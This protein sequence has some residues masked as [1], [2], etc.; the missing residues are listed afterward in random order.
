MPEQHA[1]AK[2][3]GICCVATSFL[4][5]RADTVGEHICH[6]AE[7]LQAAAVICAAHNKGHNVKYLVGSN[8]QVRVVI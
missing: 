3:H 8:T 7:Q 4:A 1:L 2:G 6:V 5:L